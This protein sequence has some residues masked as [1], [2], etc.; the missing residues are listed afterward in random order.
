[1][2]RAAPS[3]FPS[4][5][6]WG[7]Q[8]LPMSAAERFLLHTS[9]CSAVNFYLFLCNRK[10]YTCGGDRSLCAAPVKNTRV[11]RIGKTSYLTGGTIPATLTEKGFVLVRSCL[12]NSRHHSKC[13]P[14]RTPK[15]TAQVG[16]LVWEDGEEN[17]VCLFL[18]LDP[19]GWVADMRRSWGRRG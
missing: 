17:F 6:L 3:P 1:M 8:A 14:P 2:T 9:A 12:P 7:L 4:S 19:R 15:V 13:P 16:S 18:N 10:Q 5:F 11:I